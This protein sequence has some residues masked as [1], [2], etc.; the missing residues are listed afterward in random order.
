MSLMLRGLV[1]SNWEDVAP[2]VAVSAV[3]NTYLYKRHVRSSGCAIHHELLIQYHLYVAWTSG[4]VVA[5]QLLHTVVV[6]SISSDG[7]YRV[8]C[9]WDLIRSK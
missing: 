8:H 5:F 9:W 6:G 4:R 2:E 3:G 7:D 1:T